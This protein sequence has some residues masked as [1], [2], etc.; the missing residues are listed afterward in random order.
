MERKKHAP[1]RLAIAVRSSRLIARCL[2]LTITVRMERSRTPRSI[3]SAR[4]RLKSNSGTP[5]ALV[6]PGAVGVCPTSIATSGGFAT[7]AM[8]RLA[9]TALS[10]N[11][12][13]LIP[14]DIKKWR[15]RMSTDIVHAPCVGQLPLPQFRNSLIPI[16]DS[17]TDVEV[18]VARDANAREK[19]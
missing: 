6:A 5:R 12:V 1:A 10:R 4:R 7:P 17:A 19:I 13:P 18:L 14:Q 3:A 8:A 11:V 16:E 9:S 15:R 2:A